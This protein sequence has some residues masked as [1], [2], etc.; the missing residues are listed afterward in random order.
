M[1]W[2]S[3]HT[4][5]VLFSGLM[6]SVLSLGL[7][8]QYGALNSDLSKLIKPSDSLVWYQDNERYKAAFPQFQ[9]TAVVVIR[10]SDYRQVQN[11][12]RYLVDHLPK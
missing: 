10:G 1:D 11:H 9:Q 6:L 8:F 3:Q 2:L 12:T 5:P 7:F 4:G